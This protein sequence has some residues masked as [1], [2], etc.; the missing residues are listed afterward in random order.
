MREQYLEKYREYK[1]FTAKATPDYNVFHR[2][3]KTNTDEIL[4]YIW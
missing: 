1:N 4:N 2:Q 3:G